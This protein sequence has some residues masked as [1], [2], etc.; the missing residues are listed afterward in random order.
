MIDEVFPQQEKL[1]EAQFLIIVLI[2]K[3]RRKTKCQK[4]IY[5]KL[6]RWQEKA[7]K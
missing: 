5:T 4:K 3:T 6:L 1:K 7:E 2:I